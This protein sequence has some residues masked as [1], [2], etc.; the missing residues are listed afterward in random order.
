[1]KA[2]DLQKLHEELETAS[3]GCTH[4]RKCIRLDYLQMSVRVEMHQTGG[5]TTSLQYA[6]RN[7][8]AEG[9][10]ILH[11]AYVHPNTACVV[12]LRQ[13]DGR[14]AP[15]EAHAVRCRHV[16]GL[17]H[18]VGIRFKTP[19]NVRDFIDVDPM[20]GNFVL[21]HVDPQRISG[22]LLHVDDSSMDRRLVRHYLAET[23]LNIVSV[24]NG[25]QALERVKE[26]FDAIIVDN[27]LDDMGGLELVQ[28]IRGLGVA[29]PV[30]MLT[31]DAKGVSKDA[32]R[33]ASVSAI[34]PKPTSKT[35]LLQALAEFLIVKNTSVAETGGAIVSTLSQDD[36]TFRFVP[37]FVDELKKFA[38]RINQAVAG[39]DLP[40][41]RR[42]C[43]QLKGAAPALGFASIGE[44]ASAAMTAI[45]S[46]GALNAC[47]KQLRELVGMCT[48]A[49]SR[50]EQRKAG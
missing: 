38:E 36:V 25:K 31:A 12:Y 33:A 45:D 24:D 35:V 46:T 44:S 11:N 15:I 32:A 7:L 42:I 30:I 8:S 39:G 3:Q 19:I 41:A 17:I 5:G 4:A 40:T 18:E 29:V 43:Y 2:T 1:M 13:S 49:K 14:E 20:N 9:L 10:G 28:Q 27:D 6:A 47:T 37:D 50:D 22:S 26:G 34:V 23:R 16:R 48:R 21:E